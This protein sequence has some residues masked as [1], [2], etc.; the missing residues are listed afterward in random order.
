MHFFFT[1]WRTGHCL[2]FSKTA[3]LLLATEVSPCANRLQLWNNYVFKCFLIMN[4]KMPKMSCCSVNSCW[5][6]LT[7]FFLKMI[8]RAF[9]WNKYKLIHGSHHLSERAP[10]EYTLML[11]SLFLP[12]IDGYRRWLKA[13]NNTPAGEHSLTEVFGFRRLMTVHLFPS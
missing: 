6:S 8:L 7:T 10:P 11:P 13:C 12:K 5:C 3:R 9:N 4:T 1:G 2:S